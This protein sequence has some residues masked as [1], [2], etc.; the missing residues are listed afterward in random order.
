[1]LWKNDQGRRLVDDTQHS[2]LGAWTGWWNGVASADL[3]RDGDF[4]YVVTNF[5]LNTKYHA[6]ADKPALLYYGDFEGQGR[7]S[8]VEA[9]HENTVLYPVRGK[10]CSTRAM[11]FL[12]EKFTTYS[13]FARATLGEIYTP[14]CLSEAQR[15]AAN[16]LESGVLINDGQGRFSFQPLPRVAQASPAFGVVIRDFNGDRHPDIYLVQ[17][18]FSPQWETGR[19]DGGLSLLLL[20]N[21]DGTFEPVMPGRSGLSVHGDAKSAAVTDLDG[22]AWPD[23]VVGVNDDYVVAF[24]N[25]RSSEN[26]MVTV[27]LAGPRGNST[28]V[29]AKVKV[30]LVDGSSQVAEVHAGSGYLTQST[31]LLNFGLGP[32]GVI[33]QIEV[34]WPDGH[35][36]SV[37]STSLDGPILMIDYPHESDG[38]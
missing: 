2:G 14:E 16:T 24:R 38:R 22:D 33:D 5:G 1:M 15:F 9:E 17:N 27:R 34:T 20:G 13:D 10:S 6:S 30:K 8:L 26:K 23:V 7:A 18:F 19:M 29:G 36:T 4:D 25:S 35:T 37:K 12:G 31:P 3:D 11:P 28:A 32:D 21:G